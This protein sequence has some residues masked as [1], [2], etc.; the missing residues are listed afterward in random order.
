MA[1]KYL[2]VKQVKFYECGG[3]SYSVGVVK[4][5]DYNK[6]YVSISRNAVYIDKTGCNKL[7]D[8]TLYLTLSSIPN[9]IENL[10]PALRFAEQCDA[11]DKRAHIM[12][13]LF[14]LC[15]LDIVVNLFVLCATEEEAE[16]LAA[17]SAE[18]E[19]VKPFE[20]DK[21]EYEQKVKEQWKS[22]DGPDGKF[23]D[24]VA[25]G[26]RTADMFAAGARATS[27]IAN[28]MLGLCRSGDDPCEPTR[29]ISGLGLGHG[30][31]ATTSSSSIGN[32]S[33][34]K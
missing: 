18:E 4:H 7:G 1:D 19:Q 2:K 6:Y 11:K 13:S 5:F 15:L 24:I 25:T 3:T 14:L 32:F 28:A 23:E 21:K 17:S 27:H 12:N 9:L 30:G 26:V 10:E 16:A 33:I 34:V 8:Q 29:G 20:G 31:Y 22:Q